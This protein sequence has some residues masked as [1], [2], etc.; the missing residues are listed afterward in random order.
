M[1]GGLL[2][3]LVVPIA[4]TAFTVST[5]LVGKVFKIFFS[6]F[7]FLEA[8]FVE[9]GF[10]RAGFLEADFVETGLG[11]LLTLELVILTDGGGGPGLGVCLF[12]AMVLRWRDLHF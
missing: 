7:C 2:G 12:L 8:G 3:P 5:C 6:T 4:A 10:L 1:T 9:A 11:A